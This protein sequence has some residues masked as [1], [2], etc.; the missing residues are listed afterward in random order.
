MSSGSPPKAAMLRL[1][2]PSAACWSSKPKSP[3]PV[4]DESARKPERAQPVVERNANDRV[5]ANDPVLAVLVAAA[6]DIAA[7]VNIDVHRQLRVLTRSNRALDVHIQAVFVDRQTG[8]IE[9]LELRTIAAVFLRRPHI[10]PV[11]GRLGR[12]PAQFANRRRRIGNVEKVL[13][14]EGDIA[15]NRAILRLHHQRRRGG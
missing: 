14:A 6:G 9:G 7:A 5:R 8:G 10:A 4:S 12:A 2:Q 13:H 15:L 11:R 3:P 1:I